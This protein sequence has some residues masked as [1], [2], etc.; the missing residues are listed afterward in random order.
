MKHKLLLSL[1]VIASIAVA[2]EEEPDTGTLVEPTVTSALAGIS[3]T[4]SPAD[5]SET[6]AA[7]EAP[8][9][10]TARPV[11]AIGD[12]VET[13]S[14]ITV[15]LHAV[16]GDLTHEF[17]T[18][19]AGRT[20]F[21]V[22]VEGC[23]DAGKTELVAINPFFFEI[24]MADNTRYQGGIGIAEPALNHADLVA[25]DCARGWIT[26][27]VPVDGQLGTLNFAPML[28]GTSIKW[29]LQ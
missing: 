27:E 26:Y 18:P 4:G 19:A 1:L 12:T 8:E 2:C 13:E 28:S 21:A 17:F 10:P 3:S 15:T 20:Y 6:P 29:A 11:F 16:D 25:G 7:T 5:A 23:A 22:D 9:T 24:Q 14:G